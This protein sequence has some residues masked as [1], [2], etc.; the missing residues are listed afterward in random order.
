MGHYVGALHK[1]EVA[2]FSFLARAYGFLIIFVMARPERNCRE[3]VA[4]GPIPAGNSLMVASATGGALVAGL[5]I[6]SNFVD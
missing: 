4:D 3:E 2:L 5:A 6:W 1:S